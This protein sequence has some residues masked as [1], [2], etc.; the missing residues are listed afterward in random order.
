VVLGAGDGG[1]AVSQGGEAVAVADQ[2]V[3]PRQPERA[4]GQVAVPAA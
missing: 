4:S 2:D 1:A 3:A